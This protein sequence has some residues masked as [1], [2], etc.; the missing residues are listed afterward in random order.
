VRSAQHGR[1]TYPL[2]ASHQARR[3]SQRD[4]FHI[5]GTKRC[6]VGALSRFG[7][8]VFRRSVFASHRYPTSSSGRWRIAARANAPDADPR[9]TSG[10]LPAGLEA[11]TSC[12]SS[13]SVWEKAVHAGRPSDGV[14]CHLAS[15]PNPSLCGSPHAPRRAG[16]HAGRRYAHPW[17]TANK[18]GPPALRRWQP[19]GP[20]DRSR[21]SPVALRHHLSMASPFFSVS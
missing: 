13:T 5:A 12:S 4:T 7:R 20:G 8:S 16:G 11:A 2:R 6:P 17:G 19:G 15:C 3:R 14:A 9:H 1:T 10:I 21:V 18:N